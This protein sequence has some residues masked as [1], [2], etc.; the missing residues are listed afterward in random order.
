M[1][2]RLCH[3]SFVDHRQMRHG[4]DVQAD[5]LYEAVVLAVKEL[6]QEPWIEQIGPASVL[7]VEVRPPGTKHSL[8][9]QQV[10]RWL[11]GATTNPNEATR[12]AKLRMLLT[13][14]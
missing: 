10:E 12:K 6:R 13:S 9:L 5:T 3:V 7:D 1:A 11:S 4:V 8:S 2:S 14:R